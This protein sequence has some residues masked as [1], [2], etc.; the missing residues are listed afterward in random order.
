MLTDQLS[1]IRRNPA[2]ALIVLAGGL[3]I[4]VLIGVVFAHGG[5]SARAANSATRT[6]LAARSSRADSAVAGTGGGASK[7]PTV[8]PPATAG[9]NGA[10]SVQTQRRETLETAL[11]YGV[12][13]AD[14][15]GG[16]AAAAVWVGGDPEPVLSGPTTTPHRMWSM[17]KAV[18]TIAALQATHDQPDSVLS[19]AITDAIRRSDNCAIRRVIVGL[20][21]HQNQGVAGA[22]SAF[23]KV[24]A[25]A[26]ARIE[27]SPQRASPEQACVRYLN[28]HQ[29]GLPGS[30]LA[31]AAE[32]GT[33]EWTEDDAISFAHSLSEGAYGASGAYLLG[34]MGLP[35]QPPLEEPPPP[36][37]PPLDWGAGASFPAGWQ[38]AWKA[39]WGGS[40]DDPPHFLA[41]QIV[42]LHLGD[43]PVAA[44]AIFVPKIEPPND[45]PG[46][47]QAPQALELMFT[48]ARVGLEQEHVGGVQ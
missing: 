25:T 6:V 9:S 29:G 18:V 15:L 21:D 33:A 1:Q 16:E 27:R 13:R 2:L 26:D 37:A 35:K 47:T 48:A 20:Q 3:L 19:G 23:E 14:A 28:S 5:G 32:F 4:G 7:R 34:L 30:D 22:I 11:N 40:Q 45:N 8:L 17:S 41:G 42:V 39:G 44:T 12:S 43:V 24:L 36:S 31:V 10:S 38:P 46:I